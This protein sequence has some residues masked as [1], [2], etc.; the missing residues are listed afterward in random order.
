MLKYLAILGS[1]SIAVAPSA[2]AQAPSVSF[3]EIKDFKLLAGKAE[4]GTLHDVIVTSDGRL[5]QIIVGRGGVLGLGQKLNVVDLG[6]VPPPRDGAIQLGDREAVLEKLREYHPEAPRPAPMPGAPP[7]SGAN[8]QAGQTAS[9]LI[10]VSPSTPPASGRPEQPRPDQQPATRPSLD[11]AQ[12]AEQSRAA[13]KT[14]DAAEKAETGSGSTG[15]APQQGTG[16]GA[17]P[18]RADPAVAAA[19]SPAPGAGP[20]LN[21]EYGR[22]MTPAAQTNQ[23]AA[24]GASDRSE[25]AADPSAGSAS[26]GQHWRIG[27]I[28]GAKVRGQR[29]G[30]RVKDVRFDGRNVGMVVLADGGSTREVPFAALILGGTAEEPLVALRPAP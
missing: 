13:G 30:V 9:S 6:E 1:A 17:T 15:M 12:E 11:T 10:P 3:T 16:S 21:Q 4:I 22:D 18:S 19:P 2:W 7:V 14:S 27:K 5:A 26:G 20:S 25:A 8:Q 23:A 24:G 29:D 28:V